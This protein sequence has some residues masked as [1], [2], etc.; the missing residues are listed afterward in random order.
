MRLHRSGILLVLAVLPMLAQVPET[1]DYFSGYGVNAATGSVTDAH[2]SWIVPRVSCNQNTSQALFWVGIDGLL[3]VTVEQI[4]IR[5]QCA[6]NETP[7]YTAWYEFAPNGPVDIQL[8]HG[9]K[10]NDK[11]S[12][13]VHSTGNTLLS[14]SEM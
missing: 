9:V 14:H 4:G 8:K 3:S 7:V 2:G 5:V 6:G 11:I 1:H 12:A 10:P 13:K